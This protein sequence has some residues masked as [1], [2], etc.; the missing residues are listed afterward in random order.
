MALCW[1][2]DP[3]QRPTMEGVVGIAKS[4]QFCHLQDVVSLGPDVAIYS[5][6]CITQKNSHLVHG[7]QNFLLNFL[8]AVSYFPYN[9]L[10]QENNMKSK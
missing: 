5:A 1:S 7:K 9:S 4:P 3:D 8:L 6:C 2:Q 10:L